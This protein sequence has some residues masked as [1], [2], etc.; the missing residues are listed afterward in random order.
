MIKT[1]LWYC[2]ST[3]KSGYQG[4]S[5][6]ARKS[7]KR[8]WLLFADRRARQGT[9]HKI[10]GPTLGTINQVPL[11]ASATSE[12]VRTLDSWLCDS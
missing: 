11:S 3:F 1:E 2:P 4:I 5:T 9:Q 10:C 8:V 6:L 7:A 12:R